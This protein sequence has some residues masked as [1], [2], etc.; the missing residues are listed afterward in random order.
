MRAYAA[1]IAGAVA[2][3]WNIAN[4]GA[5]ATD[6]SR[7][8]HASL[9]TVGLFTTA[10][11]LVHMALQIPGGRAADRFGARRVALLAMVVL[12][13]GNVLALAA[14]HVWLALVAKAIV[15]L[16][17]GLGFVSASDYVRA[18]GGSP[19]LQG[20]YGGASV[21]SPGAALAVVPA[22]EGPLGWRAPFATAA[23]L[24]GAVG[25]LI[26][27]A[28]EAPRTR[29]HAGE[30]SAGVL[31]DRRLYR[32]AAIHTAA[33]G[34]SVVVGNWVV[35]LF[36]K[37]GAS[38]GAAAAAGSLTLLLSFFTRTWGG[39]LLRRRADVVPRAVAT[40]LVLGGAATAALALPVPFAV[41]VVTAVVIG[42][43]AGLPFAP[44]FAGA[45]AERPDAPGAAVGFVN[46][47]AAL[48]IVAGTPLLGL[49]FSLPGHGRIGFAIVGVLWATAALAT[50]RRF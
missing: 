30:I 19:F 22:L 15:G 36:Q 7:D 49:A 42:L 5:V 46:G 39:W 1:G 32:L 12:L 23:I 44:A 43:A 16:G 38:H 18:S 24:A 10:Q 40:S 47:C 37:H 20:I 34:L 27:F 6:L 14:P 11:F 8:Y 2:T 28:P 3:G 50:P 29:A 17:T 21:L 48:A 41:G 9:A 25:V 13:V 26:A 33:F 4:V 35:T 45:A 31:R